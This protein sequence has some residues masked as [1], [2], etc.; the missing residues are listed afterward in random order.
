MLDLDHVAQSLNGEVSSGQQV[1]APGP[2]HSAADRSL[3]VKLDD[4]APEGFLVHSFSGDDAIVCRDFVRERL[5]LPKP[6]PKKKGNG[7]AAK[8]G[9]WKFIR[10][11]I[12][13]QA[14]GTP[15]LRKQKYLKPDGGREFPQAHWSGGQWVNKVPK[16]KILYQL[17][18]LLKAPLT[19][20]VYITEG[21]GD[22]DALAALGFVATTAGGVS[23]TKSWTKAEFV[24]PLK[25]RCVVIVV[26]SDTPGRAYGEKVARAIDKIAELAEDPRHV[27]RG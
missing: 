18:E 4:K 11:H 23:E 25:G 24:E 16:D 9:A 20:P 27:P 10:E 2:G 6:E 26:D 15:Y 12:Y 1:L 22:A 21:E 13:R 5:G 8:G 19:S 17:A 7:K 3:S 14:D